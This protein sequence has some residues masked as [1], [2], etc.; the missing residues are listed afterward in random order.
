MELQVK[1]VLRGWLCMTFKFITARVP[2]TQWTIT[3]DLHLWQRLQHVVDS[4]QWVLL[5]YT[6]FAQTNRGCFCW[7]TAHWTQW[8]RSPSSPLPSKQSFLLSLQ[9][10]AVCESSAW[11]NAKLYHHFFIPCKSHYSHKGQSYMT[12]YK[13]KL[14]R[15]IN[16]R[17][18]IRSI[19]M[20][21]GIIIQFNSFF[22]MNF[23]RE[24]RYC[25]HELW[26]RSHDLI[27]SLILVKS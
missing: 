14:K 12:L 4:Q 23:K 16:K 24:T 7:A 8:P 13:R 17:M 9:S 6:M 3:L 22:I 11:Q 21:T 25:G 10:T 5:A 15:S 19:S 27:C 18:F 20:V 26:V 1:L 2:H